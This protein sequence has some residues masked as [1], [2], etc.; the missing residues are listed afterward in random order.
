MSSNEYQAPDLASILKT[1]ASLAPQNQQQQ[2]HQATQEHQ[3]DSYSPPPAQPP[4][5]VWQ[6]QAQARP[7]STLVNA[8][9]LIDPTTIVDWPSGLKCV[10]RTVAKHEKMLHEIRRV[11]GLVLSRDQY[12]PLSVD[13]APAR[14]RGSV[15]EGSS[16]SHREAECKEGKQKEAR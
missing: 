14:E 1:L 15:V 3:A 6:P 10:M 8:P 13:Q 12:S 5:Q 11:G 4:Q 16:G 2:G 7:S 9:K